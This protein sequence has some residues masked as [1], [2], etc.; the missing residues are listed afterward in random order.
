[1]YNSDSGACCYSV[2]DRLLVYIL[3]VE[4]QQ[5][6]TELSV[7]FGGEMADEPRCVGLIL[8]KRYFETPLQKGVYAEVSFSILAR[9]RA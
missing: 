3:S 4:N 8:S 1:M 2:S 9:R 7:N 6:F 5:L